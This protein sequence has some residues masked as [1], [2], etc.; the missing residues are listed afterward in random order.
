MHLSIA[1]TL[2]AGANFP[3]EVPY[4]AGVPLTYHWFADFHAAIAASATRVVAAGHEDI[5]IAVSIPVDPGPRALTTR[6]D[7]ARALAEH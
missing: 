1:E 5:E 2:N 6:L 7:S 4:F 3:P